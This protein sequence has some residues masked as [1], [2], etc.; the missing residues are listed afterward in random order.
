METRPVVTCFLRSEGEVLLLR[1]SDAVGSYR[2]QWGGV[3]GHVAADDGRHR[4]PETAAR[5]EI[6]EETGMADAVTLVRRGDSFQVPDDDRGVRWVVHPFLFDCGARTVTTNEETT[7]TVWVHPPEILTRK[8]VPRLWT[9]WDRVR[10]RVA[11]VREDRTHGSAWLSLRALEVLRDEAALA[12]AGRSDDLETAERDGDDWDALAALAVELREARPSMVV[13]ANRI[14]RAMAAVT[15]ASPTAVERAGTEALNHAITADRV[16]A[17]VAA[18]RAGDR[19]ATLSRSGTVREVVDATAPEAVLVAESRPGGEGV[20]IA[21]TLAESA[22]VT[23]TTDAAF[24]HE[25]DAWSAD[26]LVVGAD[27]VF[28]DGR[29][30]NKAGTRSAALSAA[31]ADVDCYAVC[32]TDK[33]APQ[34]EWDREERDSREV[35]DGN[36][37]IVVSNPTFDVTPAS[38]VT[39]ITER[40]VLEPTDIE[41]IADAHRDRSEWAERR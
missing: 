40:G 3:A 19:L 38:A 37:E 6:D 28:A 9:S 12:D 33:I 18:E 20:G 31:A 22:A 25:L 34:A 29:L 41:E 21:E 10:P 26:T 13:V 30:I 15:K 23:L 14:N 35:Y 39:V 1:R 7:E 27:R 16:A 36:A 8:T 24:G 32:A 5:A 17:A 2:G 4:D 11:T